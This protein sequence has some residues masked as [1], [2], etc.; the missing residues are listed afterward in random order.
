MKIARL[1]KSSRKGKR[2]TIIYDGKTIHFG[3]DVGS[4]FI[5][6]KDTLIKENWIKR[7]KAGNPSKINDPNS[8]LFWSL[9]LLWNKP[10]LKAS[11]R[12]I[13]DR[14]GILIRMSYD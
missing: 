3:S 6:H 14:F 2:Y 9:N 11:I 5:D 7:H 8:P 12:D 1:S 13:A 4:A 10:T